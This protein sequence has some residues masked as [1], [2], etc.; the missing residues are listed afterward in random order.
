MEKVEYTN[1]D[2]LVVGGKIQKLAN[3]ERVVLID[4][5]VEGQRIQEVYT[6]DGVLIPELCIS[7]R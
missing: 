5:L 4:L 7:E 1:Q 3:G 2:V 6:P